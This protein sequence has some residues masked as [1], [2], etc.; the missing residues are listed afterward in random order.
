[1]S[2]VIP[3]VLGALISFQRKISL[4]WGT[5]PTPSQYH[6]SLT[7]LQ[8][9]STP[10]SRDYPNICPF[11]SS[12]VSSVAPCFP[13]GPENTMGEGAGPG[14]P[15]RSVLKCHRNNFALSHRKVWVGRD[16]KGHLIPAPCH[17]QGHLPPDQVAQSPIQPGLKHLQGW[18]TGYFA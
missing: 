4:P 9:S 18:T 16:L 1:M 11:S 8:S 2:F 15:P 12:F 5:S 7:F 10:S 13:S 14:T 6:L 3:F 17:R